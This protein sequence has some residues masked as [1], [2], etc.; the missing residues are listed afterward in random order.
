M[1]CATCD[2]ENPADA[3]FCATCG[4]SFAVPCPRCGHGNRAG[5][6]FCT[7]C[8]SP[9]P[10]PV[11]ATAARASA[12]AAYT[13]PHL[14][15]KILAAR[16][17]VE[18]ERKQVTVLFADIKGSTELIRSLDPEDAQ[19]LL[20]GAID[21]MMDAVHRY[22][23]TVSQV[24]GDG[25]MALF[26]VPIAHEDHALRA[27]Y[28]AL[29]LQDGMR[30]YADD[31]R[32]TYGALVEA[33]VGISSGEVVVRAVS[34]DL[35]I[36]YTAMG[37]TVNLASRIEQLARAGTSL[38]TA[39]TLAL[40]EG[41]VEVRAVGP[42]ASKGHEALPALYELV[43]A[44]AARTR[45]QARAVR[46]LTRFV[47][48]QTEMSAIH[49][50][51][52]RTQA[53]HGQLVALV[54]DPGVGKS[55]LV[56]EVVHSHRIEGW[57]A[58]ES[59]SVS[60][61]KA[62]SWLPVI[63][64]LKA[65]C[66]VTPHDDVRAIREK[67]TGKLFAL[68][69]A[70]EASLP[71]ILA[72]LDVPVDD[73]SWL[74]LDPANRRRNTLEALKRLLLRECREQPLLVVFEDLHWIDSETQALL[75]AL[76]ET[77]PTTRMLLLVNYR[78]EY[79]H[80]WGGKSYYTQVRIDPFGGENAAALLDALLGATGVLEDDARS[81]A[82]AELKRL[83]IERTEGNP[84]FLEES[85][86]TLAETGV[87]AG[88]RGAYELVGDITAIRVPPTV[89]SMLSAR[90][91]RLAVDDKRLLQIM[92]VIGKDV[93]LPLLRAIAV[94]G[95]D[96]DAF[97]DE[98]LAEG[99]NRL[100]AAEFLYEV[101]LFP[102]QEY[103]FKH[104]LTHE[105]AYNG[106]L[107][108]RRRALHARI[109]A[110]IEAL[111]SDRLLE[112]SERLAH[113]AS[114]GELWQ[115]ACTYAR[116]AGL[117]SVARSANREAR[118]FFE[119]ALAALEHLP[120]E[121]ATLQDAI[122]VRLELRQA[123]VPLGAFPEVLVRLEEAQ[124]I[125]DALGDT[126][127]IARILPWLAYS[128]FFTPGDY[129]RSIATGERALAVGR[130]LGDVPVQVLATFY[131]AY[132]YHQS[133]DYRQAAERLEWVVATL[134]G[135][136]ARERFGMAAYPS[137]LG[138]GLLAWCLGELGEFAAG[139]VHA[140]AA[141]ALAAALDQPWSQGVA[142]T[143]LGHFYLAQGRTQQ[144]IAILERCEAL[145][146][147]WDLP[148]L[149]AFSASLLGAAYAMTG[150]HDESLPLLDR[151]AA[152]IDSE[153]G[154]ET[155]IAI[156]LVEGYLALGRTDAAAAL[157]TRALGAARA[158]SERGNEAHA[159]RLQGEI[160]LRGGRGALSHADQ[161]F[162]DALDRAEALGMRPLAARCHFALGT[163]QRR[164]GRRD[165]ARESFATAVAL[166]REMDMAYWLPEAETALETASS[167][168][169]TSMG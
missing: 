83:L 128:Y 29:A 25:I 4:A 99:L 114:R 51:L 143:Y 41:Y 56:W 126:R 157:A 23:G 62:T 113:H 15:R 132:P 159:L 148:R 68:D 24:L 30:S 144:A 63:D 100:Q 67:V 70:L 164:A 107:F 90:I 97:A 7:E 150:R 10:K 20:S 57:L 42:I 138:R 33:R 119:Q 98:E 122:D 1:R 3:R 94:D 12:P 44:A 149:V 28:A 130:E 88:E 76:A 102:V 52:D 14:A 112:M 160:A 49:A 79:R 169:D 59:G 85:V 103:T 81:R 58:L 116:R 75:D 155:R 165:A 72:L 43:G 124:K 64:L 89:Q 31:S 163:A 78:P 168:A 147:R 48:R 131:L 11:A 50:A 167:T 156:P 65:Y 66:R 45:L 146:Q 17:A 154:S 91:D 2:A 21:V 166:F 6:R 96:D 26:G 152:K 36:D 95:G 22:E 9:L 123:L 86:R 129:A 140:D 84:F 73:E 125:A 61:G 37:H 101:N 34:D 5:S 111:Y 92:A 121:R 105:V 27:C 153:G 32:R 115:Q 55:R 46:G 40:V 18:G 93:A 80:G 141:I 118:V 145:A 137:V 136:M 54:G 142:H 158:R 71:A 74:A 162:R 53:G 77:L 139:H 19:Q 110:A 87:L 47:G 106:L 104:A 16:G 60:Y 161:A 127:R 35:D 108:E 133:G 109:V 117:K 8:G 151:A 82:L 39:E 120:Q 13:P 134:I 69:R 135:D 38:L